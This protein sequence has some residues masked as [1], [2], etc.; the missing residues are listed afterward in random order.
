[1]NKEPDNKIEQKQRTR[2]QFTKEQLL[3]LELE[4]DKNNYPD[5]LQK[6]DLASKLNVKEKNVHV[7]L[8]CIYIYITKL[9]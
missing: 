2:I 5:T 4:F 1:M 8:D 7:S 9:N 3:H 6:E